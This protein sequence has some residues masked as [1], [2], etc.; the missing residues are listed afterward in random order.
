MKKLIITMAMILP[1]SFLAPGFVSAQDDNVA[2]EDTVQTDAAGNSD[3][4]ARQAERL[5]AY[6]EKAAERLTAAEERRITGACKAAQT[7]TARLT[8]EVDSIAQKRRNAYDSVSTK[9]ADITAKLIAA[10]VD[11]TEL[12]AAVDEFNV[13]A[14]AFL[15]AIDAYKVTISDLSEMDCE[16]DAEGFKAALSAAKEQRVAL[17]SSS[18]ALRVHLNDNIKPV[19]TAIRAS[20]AADTTE[21]DS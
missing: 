18:Q 19:L 11:T 7:K 14:T 8:S 6:K 20:L 2:T 12:S 16:L 5:E 15:A 10:G 13:Q 1:L 3:K 9:L 17:I 4:A 21:G